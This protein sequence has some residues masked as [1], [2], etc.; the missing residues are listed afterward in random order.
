MNL[1]VYDFNHC[2]HLETP[3]ITFRM[4]AENAHSEE[5]VCEEVLPQTDTKGK[6]SS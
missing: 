2:R 5:S 3:M 1:F 4:K 6:H